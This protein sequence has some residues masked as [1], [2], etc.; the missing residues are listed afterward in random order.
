[1]PASKLAVL[2]A[3]GLPSMRIQPVVDAPICVAALTLVVAGEVDNHAFHTAPP[4]KATLADEA[5]K[6]S[7]VARL[8]PIEPPVTSCPR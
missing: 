5:Q 7:A 8:E 4:R 1:M 6:A 3:N 2:V